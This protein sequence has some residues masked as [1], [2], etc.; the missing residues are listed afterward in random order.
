MGSE[1]SEPLENY[2]KEIYELEEI[3]GHARVS[4]LIEIFR[5][6]PVL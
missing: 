2:L 4:D 1:L 3:K 5:I 6:S